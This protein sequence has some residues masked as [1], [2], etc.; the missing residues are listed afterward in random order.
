MY[1]YTVTNNFLSVMSMSTGDLFSYWH[2]IKQRNKSSVQHWAWLGRSWLIQTSLSDET[3]S[4][5]SV[6]V[7]ISKCL[8]GFNL[9][10]GS[11]R[12]IWSS[13]SSSFV[14][15]YTQSDLMG[16]IRVRTS[17]VFVIRWLLT[18]RLVFGSLDVHRISCYYFSLWSCYRVF[19]DLLEESFL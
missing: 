12:L 9:S 13:S 15:P 11:S 4:I 19:L 17:I 16:S 5:E 1:R 3:L 6:L 8:L 18:L 7:S 14:F 10:N 2:E